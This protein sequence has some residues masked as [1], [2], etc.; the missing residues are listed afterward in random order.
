MTAAPRGEVRLDTHVVVWLFTGER[1]R[2]SARAAE[3]IE[4]HQL[5]ISPMVQLEL[6]FLHEIGRLRVGGAEIVD[7]LE[8]RIGLRA[9]TVTTSAVVAA[10]APLEWTRD[11]FDRFIAGDALASASVLLS[12]DRTMRDN[13]PLAT[14]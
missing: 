11:P 13:L 7:D 14:W 9:S 12:A 5:V 8:W 1:S 6:T 2:L 10:A 3:L 4:G